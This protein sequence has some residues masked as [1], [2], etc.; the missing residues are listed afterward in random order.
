AVTRHLG[1]GVTFSTSYEPP[2]TFARRM[3]TLDHLTKGRVGWNIVTSYLPNAAR[4]FGLEDEIPHDRRYDIADEYLEV[5]YKLWEGSWED[6]AVIVDRDQRVYT[7]PSKV[8]YIDHVGEEHTVESAVLEKPSELDPVLDVVEPVAVVAGQ[9]P[10]A[11]GDM[12]H[13]VHLE[14]VEDELL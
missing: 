5:L 7:D 10:Q 8:R 13:R 11:V 9:W 1:F 14:Q 6:D 2:F 12:A 3:S 4:N